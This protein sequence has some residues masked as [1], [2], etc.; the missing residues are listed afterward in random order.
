MKIRKL[1]QAPGVSRGQ[2]IRDFRPEVQVLPRPL[3]K[4]YYIPY[5]QNNYLLIIKLFLLLN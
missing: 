1:V 4:Y 2:P 3:M 5:F